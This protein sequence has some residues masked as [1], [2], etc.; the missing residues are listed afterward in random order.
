MCDFGDES[1]GKTHTGPVH[2][3]QKDT[4]VISTAGISVSKSCST[5]M[6]IH[7]QGNPL[8]KEFSPGF[9]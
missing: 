5:A 4:T 8:A 6:L 2:A 9:S 7:F 1:N 3:L